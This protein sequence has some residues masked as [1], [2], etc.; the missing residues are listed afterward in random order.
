MLGISGAHGRQCFPTRCPID[1]SARRGRSWP[2]LALLA[3]PFLIC[4]A[5]LLVTGWTFPTF[6][7]GDELGHWE[8]IKW[9]AASLPRFRAA[10][11]PVTAT[12]P[13]FHLVWACVVRAFGPQL[14][15]ARAGNVLLSIG[16]V[17]VLFRTLRRSFGHGR[18]TAAL[19]CAVFLSS[20]YYFGYAFR[21]LTDNMAVVGC[22]LAMEQL[23][24]FVDP[25]EP[26]RLTRFLLGCLWCGL[27]ILTRQSSLI[28]YLPFGLALLASPLGRRQF[29]VYAAAYPHLARSEPVVWETPVLPPPPC[30]ARSGRFLPRFR[31]KETPARL[32]RWA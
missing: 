7:G 21:M 25:A 16:G 19:L 13:L 26:R 32:R 15:L 20:S 24:R 10:Y 2:W 6:W 12:T 11:P 29:C 17:A 8:L 14:Q 28:L 1:Q 23:F 27:T 9:F 4:L 30:P 18:P 5:V 31:A 3:A 22:L